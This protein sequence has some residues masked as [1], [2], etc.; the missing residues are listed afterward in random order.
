MEAARPARPTTP[1][2]RRPSPRCHMKLVG[3][4]SL[5]LAALLWIHTTTVLH[6]GPGTTRLTTLALA[7]A[8]SLAIAWMWWHLFGR[9]PRRE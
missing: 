7:L 9:P 6:L 8:G 2:S 4:L 1:A 3:S 5:L